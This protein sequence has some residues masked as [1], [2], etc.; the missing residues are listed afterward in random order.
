MF[1]GF[2]MARRHN[3]RLLVTITYATLAVLMAIAIT[4]LP[5]ALHLSGRGAA[6]MWCLVLVYNVVTWSIF[7]RLANDTVLPQIHGG[8]KTTLGLTPQPRSEDDLDE[9]DLA[10]RNAAYF[11]A[12]RA[13][14][15]YS[16]FAWLVLSYSFDSSASI[17]RLLIQWLVMPLL[18]IILTL[19]PAVILWREPD[20]P[21]EAGV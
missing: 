14:A 15:V 5:S 18:A 11:T 16:I 4:I 21:Q 7:G 20:V 19:P 10:V 12:Y 8:E 9:R 2:S 3:R 1:L 6:L 17:T 13:V